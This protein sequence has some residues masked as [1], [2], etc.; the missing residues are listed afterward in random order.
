MQLPPVFDRPVY[1]SVSSELTAKLTGSVGTIDLWRNLFSY[2][3]LTINMRQKDE[4]EF[5]AILCRVRLGYITKEDVNVLE[6]RKL[7]FSSDTL[8]GRLK[9]IVQ[10]LATLPNDTVCLLPTRH[11]CN[12]LNK[13]MLQSLSGKEIQL[14][15]IDTVN[16]PAYLRQKVEAYIY[17]PIHG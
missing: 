12:E 9:E 5:A 4:K 11:M 3:E 7:S 2:D 13:Q 14:V 1:S 17:P 8:S 10:T 15:A 16:C 6:N